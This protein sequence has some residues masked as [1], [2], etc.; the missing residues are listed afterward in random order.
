MMRRAW[1]NINPQSKVTGKD[2]IVSKGFYS[3]IFIIQL[4]LWLLSLFVIKDA[5]EKSERIH[6][7]NSEQH[8][9]NKEGHLMQDTSLRYVGY[10]A[11]AARA[12]RYL[13]FTSGQC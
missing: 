5:H 1:C 4:F 6:E 10:S 12:F 11:V 2:I 8:P 7:S 9:D 3:N 13:A